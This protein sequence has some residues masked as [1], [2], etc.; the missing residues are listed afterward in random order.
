[1]RFV[2][3]FLLMSIVIWLVPFVASI[4]FFDRTGALTINFWAFKA[5]MTALQIAT[6]LFAFRRLYRRTGM[7]KP[8]WTFHL[9]TGLG[10]LAISVLLDAVTVIPLTGIPPLDYVQ[11]VVSIYLLIP[12]IS[13]YIGNQQAQLEATV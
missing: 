4:P 9:L 2:F 11:Q 7:D 3:H 1:M 12:L 10:A 8:M 13:V 5:L 6:C